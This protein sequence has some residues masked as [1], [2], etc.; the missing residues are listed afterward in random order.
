MGTGGVPESPEAQGARFEDTF[1]E[2]LTRLLRDD[3]ELTRVEVLPRSR[4]RQG[5]RDIQAKWQSQAG[6][7]RHWHFECKSKQQGLIAVEEFA[8]KL[9]QEALTSHDIDVWCLA[10]SNAEPSNE[11]DD[12]LEAAP[13]TLGFD[14]ALTAISPLRQGLKLLYSCHPDLHRTQYGSQ[15]HGITK[16]ERQR[17]I[18]GFG[19]WLEE[20]S[21]KR[22]SGGPTGW[23]LLTPRRV[24][25]SPASER[26]AKAYLRGLT[27]TCPWQ[28]V[29]DGWSVTRT[30][31]EGVLLGFLDSAAPGF[32]YEWLISAGGEGKSTV[33]R[34]VVWSVLNTRKDVKVLWADEDALAV[35]P[36]SWLGELQKGSRVFMLIDGTGQFSGLKDGLG[37]SA[38]LAERDITVLLLMADRGNLWHGRRARQAIPSRARKAALK[39]P[40]L[41][42]AE[43]EE[44][45]QKLEAHELLEHSRRKQAATMLASAVSGA[46][47]ASRRNRWETSWLVPTVLEAVDPE[48]R[49]F[50]RILG[51]VL[52][53]LQEEQGSALNLMLA[54]AL[55]HAAGSA[56]P[57]DLA[58]RLVGSASDLELAIDVLDQELETQLDFADR[59]V[60]KTRLVTH[61]TAVSNGF[62]RAACSNEAL[63]RRLSGI[64]RLLP[65]LMKPEYSA[66]SALRED[67]FELLDLTVRYLEQLGIDRALAVIL[68]EAW[69][70][71]DPNGFLALHRLGNAFLRWIQSEL[72]SGK[73]SDDELRQLVSQSRAAFEESLTVTEAVLARDLIPAPY[74]GY[75]QGKQE[76]FTYNSW[77]VLEA[78]VGTEHRRRRLGGET[79]LWRSV[80]LAMLS[81]EH[82]N[83]HREAVSVGLLA[84]VLITLG[85]FELAAPIL[86]YGVSL[87]DTKRQLADDLSAKLK[88]AGVAL[89]EGSIGTL[90][91]GLE[92]VVTR[93]LVPNWAVLEMKVARGPQAALVDALSRL[94]SEWGAKGTIE[95]PAQL[96]QI[97]T[98]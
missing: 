24:M 14:F 97:P 89:P 82:Q 44:L 13:R 90:A 15:A 3:L 98:S 54:I 70:R 68:L 34:S 31:I 88:R 11:T 83:G 18:Q 81:L 74:R 25:D 72:R 19:E 47:A 52:E 4:G 40:P 73:M 27:V 37:I 80:L 65:D 16:G 48:Q 62:V 10:A 23:T 46:H 9:M 7:L 20:W 1:A 21:D 22:P 50:E 79:D 45:I 56:I 57:L 95:K 67:R 58:E 39:L 93:L 5:G 91:K 78:T 77:A 76:R 64:C 69:V 51:S 86:G 55:L 85:E 2:L 43:Q 38:L 59:V 84:R 26:D 96:V 8:G 42:A 35:L 41:S 94:S 28:A 60:R 6:R 87:A 92:A 49:P 32:R 66:E 29:V 75:D 30:E 53:E 36:L 33:L 63:L 17:L 12:L 71:L 61:G